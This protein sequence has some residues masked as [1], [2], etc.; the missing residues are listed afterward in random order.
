MAGFGTVIAI[1]LIF[2]GFVSAQMREFRADTRAV[3]AI[4]AEVGSARQMQLH[5]ANLW[6]YITDAS[7]THEEAALTKLAKA[8]FDAALLL[9]ERLV[10]MNADDAAH[11]R[12]LEELRTAL[13]DVL[14]AG[15]RMYVA[16]GR[17][18]DA[19]DAAMKEFDLAS[20]RAIETVSVIVKEMEKESDAASEEMQAM[21]MRA[22]WITL[23]ACAVGSLA[24]LGISIALSL[25]ITR[26]LNRV[27]GSLSAGADQVAAAS[28]QTSSSSQNVA[29]SASEMA[30]SLEES[31]SA[32]EEMTSMIQQN[33]EH[34]GQANLLMK[35]TRITVDGANSAMIEMQSG[36]NEIKSNS[37]DIAKIIKVIEEIAFQTNLL[38]LNAAVEA[39]RAGE[40]GKGFAV[41]AE[42]VRNLAQRAGTSAR[43]TG[44]LIDKA[45]KTVNDG[46]VKV[47]GVAKG[48]KDITESSVKVGNLVEEISTASREQAQGIGQINTA[49]GEMDKTTQGVAANSEETAAAAEEMSSQAI[50]LQE[51]VHALIVL[52]EGGMSPRETR[53]EAGAGKERGREQER[54]PEKRVLSHRRT[55]PA[56]RIRERI[57]PEKVIP[58]KSGDFSEF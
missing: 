13:P 34:A 36:M 49:V 23:I 48:L 27:I 40:H 39:A 41:V 38:A 4:A 6:Q 42:E 50:A 19:G 30:A 15:E 53:D 3:S 26:P 32:I 2:G 31:S 17:S 16:Y 37:D 8:E 22:L 58:L 10:A 57:D 44:A 56:T 43:E 5:I 9:R 33:A 55:S 52:V 51:N 7:L 25:A 46:L 14:N 21:S 18:R 20:A 24:A 35:N 29:Q 54:A 45:V 11:L 1:F 12:R 47:T 28:E